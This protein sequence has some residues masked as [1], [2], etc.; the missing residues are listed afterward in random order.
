MKAGQSVIARSALRKIFERIGA[1][2]HNTA[3]RVEFSDGSRYQTDASKKQSGVL[4]RFRTRRAEWHT[5]L[6][7]YEGL[8]ESFISGDVDL[9]GEQPIAALARLGRST[10][11]VPGRFWTDMLRNPLNAT[12]Q[13]AQEWRQDGSDREQA[14]R[15]AEFH[16]SLPPALFEHALGETVGYSEGLWTPETKTLNQAKFNNYEY[17]CRKLRLEPGMKVLE[18]GAGWGYM[19]IYMA[20]RYRVDVTVYNPVRR[21]NDYMRERFRRHGL[22]EKIR[23][24]EGDHRDIAQESGRFDRF[25][26]IGVHEHAGHSLK[27]YRLWARSIAAALKEGGVGV[28]STTSLMV[29]ERTN[30][31]T[32]KYIFRGGHLPSLPDTLA[33]FDRAGLMLVEVENLWSHY[34]RTVDEWRKNFARA[35]PEIQKSDPSVFTERFRRIWT[36]YLEGTEEVF[37]SFLDL[38][39]IVFTKGRGADYYPLLRGSHDVE[40]ELIGGDQ[41]PECYP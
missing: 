28:V 20:K 34:Q 18:V 31:L 15:N 2:P 25:V 4:V 29:R 23:L 41:E 6:F 22:D 24:V 17:V 3:L 19:P 1:G 12:R 14:I 26:S 36:M 38:S 7:F 27:Q 13:W 35:W 11:I 33:A 8:F 16:Y 5:L 21:Q 39:H 9:E 37:G 40:A 32:L 30:L 10:G